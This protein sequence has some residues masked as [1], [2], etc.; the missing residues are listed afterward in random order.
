MHIRPVCAG[1]SR[2]MVSEA[3]A[4]AGTTVNSVIA[5]DQHFHPDCFRCGACDDVIKINADSGNNEEGFVPFPPFSGFAE[6]GHEPINPVLR[7]RPICLSC[8]TKS[9]KCGGCGDPI[10]A[11]DRLGFSGAKFHPACLNCFSCK[12]NLA[13]AEFAEI[14]GKAVCRGCEP[15]FGLIF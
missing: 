5:M 8:A 12:T 1:C 9:D 14:G 7:L 4:S 11:G 3:Q 15:K 10:V 13:V 2:F 6:P